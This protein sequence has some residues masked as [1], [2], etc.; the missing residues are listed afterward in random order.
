MPM[1]GQAKAQTA[2]IL[3]NEPFGICPQLLGERKFPLPGSGSPTEVGVCP[4]HPHSTFFNILF[5][6]FFFGWKKFF[7]DYDG[8]K[9]H[10]TL[11]P[12]QQKKK[13]KKKKKKGKPGKGV[14]Y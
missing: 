7:V 12:L 4:R 1:R 11:R 6:F 3:G 10:K 14:S 2:Q 8:I 5:F 9:G 13:K